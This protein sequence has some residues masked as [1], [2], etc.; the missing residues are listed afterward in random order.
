MSLWHKPLEELDFADVE[1]FCQ[2]IPPPREGHRL[3][4]KVSMPTHLERLLSAFANTLGGIVILGV[5]GDARNEPIWPP[6]GLPDSPGISEQIQ[7]KANQA[8]YPALE[9]E[10]SRNL[11][12]PRNPS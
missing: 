2:Q 12:N 9:V 6:R 3:D 1:A 5:E 7:Q 10:I 11:Q 8:I 4:F